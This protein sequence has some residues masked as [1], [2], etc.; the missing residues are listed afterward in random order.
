M[1][2]PPLALLLL[3]TA[4]PTLWDR[5]AEAPRGPE[6]V[7]RASELLLGTPYEK[8]PLGEGAGPDSKPRFRLDAFDCQTF[9]ETALALGEADGAAQAHAILDDIRYTGA[10][11]FTERNH[12]MMSQ[13]VPSN[14][15][16]GYLA[17]PPGELPLAEKV[18]TE[19]SWK[20]RAVKNIE[21][22]RDRVPIGRFTLPLTDLDALEAHAAEIPS[23][24]VMLIV[25]EDKPGN[26]DRVT[27]LGFVIEK[28][29]ATLYRH[30]SDVFK[31]V[32]DEPIAHF[33]ARNR[34]YEYKVSGV[35][36]LELGDNAAR[37]ET[38]APPVET[39]GQRQ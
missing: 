11:S 15:S 9:V 14:L 31:R 1:L 17:L 29:K 22:P 8:H 4:T 12:Y 10:P 30:A 34:R 27:H 26:P 36:L 33:V 24:T 5:L 19:K 38:L 23:G 35:S 39:A 20:A 25:R 21:L 6:R 32:V 3:A 37:V 2:A 28:G 13:W 18:I 7:V 16:K